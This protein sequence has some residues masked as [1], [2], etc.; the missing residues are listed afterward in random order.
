MKRRMVIASLLAGSLAVASVGAATAHECVI[1]SR[2]AQGDA[3]A[4]H[5][6]RWITLTLADVLGFIHTEIPGQADMPLTPAQI[7]WAVA[8]R[9][10]LP[11]S[12]VTR[13]DKTIGAGSANPNIADGRGLDHLAALVGPQVGALYFAALAH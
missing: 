3:G 11:S 8:N 10:D 13:G 12:W 4:T 2:S 9:G 6:S 7:E 5:S 1:S